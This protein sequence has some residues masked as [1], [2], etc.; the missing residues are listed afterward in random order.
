MRKPLIYPGARRT[1][2]EELQEEGFRRAQYPC[3][4]LWGGDYRPLLFT[5]PSG[6]CPEEREAV[7]GSAQGK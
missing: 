2:I 6:K 4:Q 3:V 7:W 1:M 5:F